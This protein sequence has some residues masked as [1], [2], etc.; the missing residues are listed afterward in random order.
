MENKDLIISDSMSI[1]DNLESKTNTSNSPIK[2]VIKIYDKEG[3]LIKTVHN[4]VVNG[5]RYLLYALFLNY[6]LYG[7]HEETEK[8]KI[9]P[10]TAIAVG[11]N[12]DQQIVLPTLTGSIFTINFSYTTDTIKTTNTLNFD[13]VVNIS[14]N[15]KSYELNVNDT[16]SGVSIDVDPYEFKVTFKSTVH[17]STEFKQF[18]QIYLSYKIPNQDGGRTNFLFSR[19]IMDPV[20]LG[21]DGEYSIHYSLFF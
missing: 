5:G 13:N 10:N 8:S 14:T 9:V 21:A 6:G 19:V 2:G 12:P 11:T 17:G 3:N 20:Y 7:S 16:E 15:H 18:N 1:S 4:M